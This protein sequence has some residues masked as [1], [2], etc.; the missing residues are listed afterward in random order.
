M[1][2]L[3]QAEHYVTLDHNQTCASLTWLEEQQKLDGSFLELAWVTHREMLGGVNGDVSHTA[4]ILIALLECECSGEQHDLVI[5]RAVNYIV[6]HIDWT[7]RPLTVAIAAYALTLA[8]HSAGDQLFDRLKD[9]ARS[10]AEGFTYWEPARSETQFGDH[11]I[12]Y[13][14]KRKPGA[15]AVEV[16]SYAL[17]TFL[18]RGDVST[19]TSIVGWL[20]QQRNSHGAFVSTQDTVVGLQALSEYSIKSYSAILDMTCHIRS[21]VD[22]RFRKSISLTPEDA[23]VLKSVPKV[24]TGGKIHFEAEGTGVGLMQVEVRFNVPDEEMACRYE[25]TV[26]THQQRTLLQSFF[27]S[28]RKSKCE[29]CAIT[30]KEDEDDDDYADEEEDYEDFV[31]PSVMPRILWNWRRRQGAGQGQS[32]YNGYW[33]EKEE[34]KTSTPPPVK[35]GPLFGSRIGRPRRSTRAFSAT[36]ICI[37]ICLRFLGEQTTGMS[38]VDAGLLTGYAPVDVDLEEL[39]A[40]GKIDHY[41]KSKRSV[42]LYID[43][44]PSKSMTCVK[45]RAR[46][47]HMAQ[48]VQPAKVQVFDYYN[49]DDRCTV[50]YKSDNRSGQLVNFCDD[51]KQICQ[52]LESR[53]SFCQESWEGLRWMD[54]VKFACNNASH[55]LVVKALDRDLEKVGFE[56]ILGQITTVTAQKGH[57]QLKPGDK[58]ILLKRAS[59]FCPRVTPG[60]SYLMMLS[61]P[62]RFRDINGNQIYAFLLDKRVLAVHLV[63][64]LRGLTGLQRENAKNVRRAMRRL[65]RRGCTFGTSKSKGRKLKEKRKN[66]NRSRNKKKKVARDGKKKKMRNGRYRS[67][68]AKRRRRRRR[69]RRRSSTPE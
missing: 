64:Q 13:W 63:K 68:L 25:L 5:D 19:A 12:P 38:I 36:V 2:T 1:K 3:C 40:V 58:V 67:G 31:F 8:G 32:S 7:D 26:N 30:C 22:D 45:F 49:P 33:G 10:S 24:P 46:Q 20:L 53:C 69:R 44:V 55:V 60:E 15:L 47:D 17:L 34:M 6:D 57:H 29:P 39:K 28:K 50:F 59:C 21:E 61:Q 66:K 14:Y 11:N 65:K 48:N 35:F 4:Y 27:G 18:A 16:T 56:R 51:K 52:C 43:Q 41:E 9:T 37:E 62:K 54:M 42:V 23:M